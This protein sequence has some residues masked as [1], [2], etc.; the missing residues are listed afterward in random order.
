MIYTENVRYCIGK[1][2]DTEEYAL[3]GVVEFPIITE[4][5]SHPFTTTHIIGKNKLVSR[6]YDEVFL[7][8]P[9]IIK[10]HGTEFMDLTVEV[11][12]DDYS[13]MESMT[14]NG[15]TLNPENESFTMH[16]PV[17]FNKDAF[18]HV[19]HKISNGV[20][21]KKVNNSWQEVEPVSPPTIQDVIFDV[22]G[23]G[24]DWSNENNKEYDDYDE[25]ED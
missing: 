24:Q 4:K 11:N 18:R 23:L 9:K 3:L 12:R 17:R 10:N 6:S 5:L 25:Q 14:F 2:A 22:L 16:L 8:P 21:Y 20:L 15:V 1:I 19:T 13:N 7:C